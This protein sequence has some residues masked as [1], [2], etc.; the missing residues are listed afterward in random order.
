MDFMENTYIGIQHNVMMLL[1]NNKYLES[2][3]HLICIINLPVWA[4][5]KIDW[6]ELWIFILKKFRTFNFIHTVS[7]LWNSNLLP[8]QITDNAEICPKL[9]C[10]PIYWW[11]TRTGKL[12][13]L[14]PSPHRKNWDK[15]G[16]R[17]LTESSHL[18]VES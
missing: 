8:N 9:F 12:M 11:L 18:F 3:F 7:W 15:H 4:G 1:R 17:C 10:N 6:S 14:S 16:H 5:N 13:I 2:E